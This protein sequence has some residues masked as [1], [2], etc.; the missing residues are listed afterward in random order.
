MLPRTPQDSCSGRPTP[1]MLA[2]RYVEIAAEEDLTVQPYQPPQAVESTAPAR[3]A[4]DQL[5][6]VSIVIEGD[7]DLTVR[8]G[9]TE[10]TTPTP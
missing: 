8:P 4:S 1:E 6:G 9:A 5:A 2:G 3:P 7:E 10:R